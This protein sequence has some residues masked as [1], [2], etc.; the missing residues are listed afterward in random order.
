LIKDINT[1]GMILSRYEADATLCKKG[2]KE[3]L[4]N[5][6]Q[7]RKA[8]IE[9]LEDV[10]PTF[11]SL[12]RRVAAKLIYFKYLPTLLAWRKD[13]LAMKER[14]SQEIFRERQAEYV[15]LPGM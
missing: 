3:A 2:A 6:V 7:D 8:Y 13:C 4:G 9:S 1:I 15:T 5:F 11:S 12:I 14:E 10:R